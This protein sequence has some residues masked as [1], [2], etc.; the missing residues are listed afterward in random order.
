MKKVPFI[1]SG[2]ALKLES[3]YQCSKSTAIKSPST[4]PSAGRIFRIAHAK[5]SMHVPVSG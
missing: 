5:N 4:I 1:Y 2:T 3:G